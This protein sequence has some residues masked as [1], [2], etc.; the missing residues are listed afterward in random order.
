MRSFDPALI[1]LARGGDRV[2]LERLLCDARPD[3]HRLA[4][5]V[6]AAED[7]EDAVQEALFQA[8]RRIGTLRTVLAFGGWLFRI[9]VRTC[10]RMMFGRAAAEELTEDLVIQE[11]EPVDLRRELVRALSSLP[12][13]YREVLIWRD[14]KE[15]S[16]AETAV[17]LEISVDAVK[18]RLHRARE[19]MR[20]QLGQG[21][22]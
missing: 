16:A 17:E 15:L 10:R 11:P 22:R 21:D 14:V 20:E 13:S 3:L 5:R 19:M 12:Q 9:M 1:E 4:W 6:C 2:A 18:S 7:A 8:S